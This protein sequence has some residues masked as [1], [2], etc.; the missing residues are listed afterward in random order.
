MVAILPALGQVKEDLVALLDRTAAEHACRELGHRWRDRQ[1]DPF[2]TLHSFILQVLI[3]NTAMTH[4]P[5]LTGERFSA[6][7]YC[8]ARQRPWKSSPRR[9]T[10][11]RS[12]R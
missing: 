4:L 1:L 3:Q 12:P 7:A 2:T 6:S 9:S 11:S 5:H 8:Q 10:R